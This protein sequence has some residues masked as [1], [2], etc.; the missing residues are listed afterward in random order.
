M[1]VY[2]ATFTVPSDGMSDLTTFLCEVQG[3]NNL[4][5]SLTEVPSP[6][7]TKEGQAK[8][9]DHQWREDTP[10]HSI[11]LEK[12]RQDALA[13]AHNTK[14]MLPPLPELNLAT[15]RELVSVVD[16]C[17]MQYHSGYVCSQL[18]LLV[19]TFNTV[20]DCIVYP[21]D[22]GK[23]IVD[24]QNGVGKILL[25]LFF[26]CLIA[27]PE[28]LVEGMKYMLTHTREDGIMEKSVLQKCA[29]ISSMIQRGFVVPR[30][31]PNSN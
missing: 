31:I 17:V 15:F 30:A 3:M 27:N 7:D 1:E 24:S 18:C 13:V 19:K 12:K 28:E 29:M 25:D 6:R 16:G 26:N 5:A 2:P 20:Y 23:C 22:H 21:T 9:R 8:R 11:L 4:A 10:F 14:R